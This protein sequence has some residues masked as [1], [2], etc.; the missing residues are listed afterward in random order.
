MLDVDPNLRDAIWLRDF[1]V[2]RMASTM[3]GQKFPIDRQSRMEVFGTWVDTDRCKS[4]TM[5][6]IRPVFH[7]AHLGPSINCES[8]SNPLKGLCADSTNSSR[9]H[10]RG[11]LASSPIYSPVNDW[12]LTGEHYGNLSILITKLN[13][14]SLFA[15]NFGSRKLLDDC[16]EGRVLT[17]SLG[18]ERI[19][20]FAEHGKG[21]HLGSIIRLTII[22]C[23]VPTYTNEK[24]IT[25]KNC[26]KETELVLNSKIVGG[27]N[28]GTSRIAL[29]TFHRGMYAH[30]EID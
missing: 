30:T 5:S 26:E 1:A 21:H 29:D 18:S 16:R 9:E 13:L 24:S 3:V 25:C 23:G 15:A 17:S 22:S 14:V 10:D 7:I 19:C 12:Y 27:V 20:S 6:L 28:F 8:D 2:K 11:L 4:F